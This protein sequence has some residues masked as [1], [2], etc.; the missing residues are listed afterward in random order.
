MTKR[1]LL[2]KDLCKREPG[3]LGRSG[4]RA[5]HLQVLE[6]DLETQKAV[7]PLLQNKVLRRIIQSFTNDDSGRMDYWACN[8]EVL[9]LLHEAKRKMEEGYISEKEMES[10]LIAHLRV[11]RLNLTR[12]ILQNVHEL[13]KNA[14]SQPV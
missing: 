10:L 8:P 6:A 2:C 12:Q 13:G 1:L 4:V 9:R 11:S 14:S 3:R 5:A 7:A